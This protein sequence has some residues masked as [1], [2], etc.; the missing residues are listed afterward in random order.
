MSITVRNNSVRI[1][2]NRLKQSSALSKIYNLH[3]IHNQN[4]QN[5][6]RSPL[7]SSTSSYQKKF[8][9]VY[10]SKV[11]TQTDSVNADKFWN[12]RSVV[13]KGGTPLKERKQGQNLSKMKS[14]KRKKFKESVRSRK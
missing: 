8:T 4:L 11:N 10:S 6:N 14:I 7:K 2:T 13:S 9:Q 3:P 5:S 1:S 12:S